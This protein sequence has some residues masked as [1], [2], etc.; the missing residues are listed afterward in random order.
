MFLWSRPYRDHQTT[1]YDKC[2]I[3]KRG[4]TNG[5]PD[6]FLGDQACR[7]LYTMEVVYDESSMTFFLFQSGIDSFFRLSVGQDD[8]QEGMINLITRN[9]ADQFRRAAT[10]GGFSPGQIRD[11]RYQTLALRCASPRTPQST[12]DRCAMEHE[13]LLSRLLPPS[14]DTFHRKDAL[15]IS[16]FHGLPCTLCKANLPPYSPARAF[17]TL[18]CQKIELRP[19]EFAKLIGRPA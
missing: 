18:A 14:L 1:I 2:R 4:T 3:K 6:L 8:H 9:K 5:G 16:G 15:S 19:H 13:L 12:D 17:L 10:D 11:E 7:S